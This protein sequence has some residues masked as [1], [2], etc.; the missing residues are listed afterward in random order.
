MQ[1]NAQ[2]LQASDY[3]LINGFCGSQIFHKN[4]LTVLL[5]AGIVGRRVTTGR[6]S[7]WWLFLLSALPLLAFHHHT[8]EVVAFDFGDSAKASASDVPAESPESD[9]YD[10]SF[11]PGYAGTQRPAHHCARGAIQR[12]QPNAQPIPVPG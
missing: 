1:G 9:L 6:N 12:T 3:A 8:S 10:L 5:C 11:V 2:Q 7:D 4:H